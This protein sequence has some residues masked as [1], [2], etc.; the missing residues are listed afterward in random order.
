MAVW[1]RRGVCAFTPLSV[2]RLTLSQTV[3][4]LDL[5][6]YDVQR[7]AQEHGIALGATAPQYTDKP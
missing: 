4:L 5:S 6:V 3:Q 7:K 1:C 2:G